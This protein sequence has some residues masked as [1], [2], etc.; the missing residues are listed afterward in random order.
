M[1]KSTSKIKRVKVSGGVPLAI[2]SVSTDVVLL[3]KDAKKTS[4][5]LF[6]S[7]S[8]NGVDFIPESKKV[9]IKTLSKKPEKINLCYNFSINK[10]P[11]GFVMTYF[12]KGNLNKKN[13]Q[14]DKL[15]VARSTD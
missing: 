14:K 7:W 5:S 13:I 4:N 10:T 11:N 9:T 3:S 15:I 1:K 6:L 12:R 8:K 2:V